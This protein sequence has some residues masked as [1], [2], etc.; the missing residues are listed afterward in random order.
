MFYFLSI[1]KYTFEKY[2]IKKEI[3]LLILISTQGLEKGTKGQKVDLQWQN[4]LKTGAG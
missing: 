3:I 2:I 1:F 4:Q